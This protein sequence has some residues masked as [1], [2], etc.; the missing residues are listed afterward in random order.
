[1]NEIDRDALTRAIVA[2]RAESASRNRQ[3]EAMFADPKRSWERVARFC[4]YS[5]QIES[6]GLKPH[7]TA[8]MWARSPDLEKPFG[9]PR[10]EREAAEIR[11][12]LQML[13]LSTFEPNPL[14]A[15]AEAERLRLR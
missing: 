6:L 14:A 13:G 1:M 8:P 3:I 7:E 5:A 2:A 9:D 15:I 11:K 12:K 10:G 4:A